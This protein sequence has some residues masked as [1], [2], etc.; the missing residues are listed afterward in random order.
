MNNFKQF[1][2]EVSYA[3]TFVPSED[4]AKPKAMSDKVGDTDSARR[5]VKEKPGVPAEELE[6][7]LKRLNIDRNDKKAVKKVH[8]RLYMRYYRKSKDRAGSAG[9]DDRD[10]RL[11]ESYDGSVVGKLRKHFDSLNDPDYDVQDHWSNEW[12]DAP[13]R[14]D[15]EVSHVMSGI[16]HDEAVEKMRKKLED[17]GAKDVRV[18]DNTAQLGKGVHKNAFAATAIKFRDNGFDAV[19]GINSFGDKNNPNHVYTCVSDRYDNPDLE[20][21]RDL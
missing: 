15:F 6:S 8:T 10:S 14:P 12:S 2:T 5:F 21:A 20:P 17:H 16:T 18:E 7:E 13:N 11:T 3:K 4:D 19:A 1:L 9:L